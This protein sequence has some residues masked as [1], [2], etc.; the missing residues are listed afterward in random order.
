MSPTI[1]TSS[2]IRKKAQIQGSQKVPNVFRREQSVPQPAIPFL[3]V[4][5]RR[6]ALYVQENI[7]SC[8]HC[9]AVSIREKW[10]VN[11]IHSLASKWIN[12]LLLQ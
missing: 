1:A 6:F 9:Y 4:T 11:Q 8:I 10:E 5:L 2:T 12:G 7:Y 3:S